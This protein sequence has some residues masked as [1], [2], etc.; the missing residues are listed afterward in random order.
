MRRFLEVIGDREPIEAALVS[1]LPQPSQ[2][3][4]RPA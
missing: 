4:E 2:L 3:V 1:E